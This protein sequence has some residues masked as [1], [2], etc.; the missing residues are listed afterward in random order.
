MKIMKYLKYILVAVVS[1]TFAACQEEPY[2][3]GEPDSLFCQGL[4]FPQDQAGDITLDPKDPKVLSFTVERAVEDGEA[5]VPYELICSEEGFFE[6]EDNYLFFDDGQKK[7]KFNVHFSDDYEIGKKYSCTI[8]V[9]D[10]EYVS[11]YA[12][13]SSELSFSVTVVKWDKVINGGADMGKWRDDF[14][15]SLAMGVGATLENPYLEKEVEVY[16]RSDMPGYYR[17]DGIYTPEYISEMVQGDESLAGSLSDY[18]PASSIFIN[19]TDPDKVYIDAQLA[20]MNPYDF[21][22]GVLGT[23]VLI[24]SDVQEVFLSGYSNSYGK[25]KDG[26]ITF[27]DNSLMIYLPVGLMIPGNQAGKTR[28]VMPGYRGYDYSVAVTNSPSENGVMPLHFVLGDDVAEVKYQ[29]F[30]GH[31]SDVEM[32]SKLESVKNATVGVK[33][34]TES[35]TYDFSTSKTGFYTLVACSFDSAGNYREYDYLKFGYDTAKDPKD[36]DINL[37]LIVSDKH[38]ATG[39]T[40]ENSMEFYV[41]GNDIK[42]AKVALYKKIHYEDF[43]EAIDAEFKYYISALD[44][45]QLD[46]LNKVGYTGV[47]DGLTPGTEYILVAYADNGYHSGFFTATATTEGVFDLMDAEFTFYDLPARLQTDTHDDYF[48]TWDV[49]SLDPFTATK[50]GRTKRG[51]A[52]FKDKKDVMYD[53]DGNVTTVPGNADYIMDYISLEGMHPNLAKKGLKDAIDFEYYEGFIYSMMT[54]VP[55]MTVEGQKVYPT[56]AYLYFTNTGLSPYLENG[57][58]IGG[59]ITEEKD[60]IALVGNPQASAPYMAMLMCYFT[61]P[62]YSG[63]GYLFEEDAHAYPLLVSPDSKYASYGKS[64]ASL[65]V[66]A[67]CKRVA[68]ELEKGQ[69]NYVETARGYIM[70][71]IDKIRK[72]PYNYMENALETSVSFERAAVEFTAEL[73][74]EKTAEGRLSELD[75][76]ERKLR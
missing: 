38:G 58:M 1:L 17:V 74:S 50:W 72:T 20:F 29:V 12:L 51:T 64:S 6:L 32:V 61:D 56:N 36:V 47:V 28:L 9:T 73:S 75:L 8:R 24:C 23:P 46:S 7:A 26:V 40:A 49:W 68:F 54:Q 45:Y 35:G 5:E 57:A 2:S 19:A 25:L 15:T 66:P 63:N 34:V 67:A 4:F 22:E 10:P 31:V 37:G 33:R 44:R 76:V 27:P 21:T 70:S 48:K 53:S 69:G 11:K 55:E 16:Q 39:R 30:D 59:F 13:S 14:F 60:V 3:Q 71:T 62:S 43:R 41:Y 65:S 18:F 42:E 52:T